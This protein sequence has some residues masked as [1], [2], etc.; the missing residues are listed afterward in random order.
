[1]VRA[2]TLC[3]RIDAAGKKGLAR[4]PMAG[5]H[6]GAAV[7]LKT[8]IARAEAKIRAKRQL[9]GRVVSP[10][11]SSERSGPF[12]R[13]LATAFWGA[14]GGCT[15]LPGVGAV[16]ESAPKGWSRR[17]HGVPAETLFGRKVGPGFCRDARRPGRQTDAYFQ[18][19]C[20]GLRGSSHAL[21]RRAF[22]EGK[23]LAIALVMEK[24]YLSRM[25][26]YKGAWQRHGG[27]LPW[28]KNARAS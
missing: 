6:R 8:V 2:G 1:M 25:R 20:D 4:S 26:S 23:V 17:S 21:Q 5:I 18:R 3:G 14:Q 7:Q 19:V 9:W 13:V 24:G 15:G 27:V 22:V 16:A 12:G 11:G 28:H 10:P